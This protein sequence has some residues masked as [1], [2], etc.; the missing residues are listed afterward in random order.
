MAAVAN[1]V[2]WLSRSRRVAL[3]S[4]QSIPSDAITSPVAKD[5]L[6]IGFDTEI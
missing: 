4:E 1:C 6:V 3:S 2:A 5:N